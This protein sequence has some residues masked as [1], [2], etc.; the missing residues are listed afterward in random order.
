MVYCRKCAAPMTEGDLVCTRCGTPVV[1]AVRQSEKDERIKDLE[2]YR[3]LLSEN[4]ELK[5]MIKPQSEFPMYDS[6]DYKKRSFIRYFWPFII[7][8]VA[9]YTIIYILS[10]IITFSSLETIVTTSRSAERVSSRLLGD[11]YGGLFVGIIVAVLI[12]VIGIKISKSKQN[13]FNSNAE[14]MNMQITEKYR[15]GLKNQKMIDIYQENLHNMRMYE[16]LVPE[17]F[18]TAEKVD[19]IIELLK[20]DKAN[21][22]DE[23]CAML[24]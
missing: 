11:T 24:S 19:M 7:G 17:E 1:N 21:T 10:I 15:A 2:E 20:A 5:R 8:A 18:Q 6:S 4:E 23:A 16:N 12:I 14:F 9:A 13:A 3:T 22:I